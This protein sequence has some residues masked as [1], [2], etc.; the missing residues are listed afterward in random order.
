[1]LCELNGETCSGRGSC[2]PGMLG[3]VCDSK[4]FIGEFCERVD[5]GYTSD[6]MRTKYHVFS[7]EKVESAIRW[8]LVF[9][10]FPLLSLFQLI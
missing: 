9:L 2:G 1:M 7:L 6:G 4:L 3:C 5:S 10:L 8:I